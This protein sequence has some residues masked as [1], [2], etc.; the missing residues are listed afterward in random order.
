[1]PSAG[2]LKEATCEIG[3][4]GSVAGLAFSGGVGTETG[5]FAT[6]DVGGVAAAAAAVWGDASGFDWGGEAGRGE[7][8][9]CGGGATGEVVR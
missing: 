7:S 9:G 2:L 3:R 1:M 4:G 6:R 8:G 5:V